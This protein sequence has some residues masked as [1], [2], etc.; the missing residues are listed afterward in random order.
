MPGPSPEGR[1]KSGIEG[2]CNHLRLLKN[3]MPS[4]RAARPRGSEPGNAITE[5]R[6][7]RGL[8]FDFVALRLVS[9]ET[10]ASYGAPDACSSDGARWKSD[11]FQEM[12]EQIADN[13]ADECADGCRG[14]RVWR[15]LLGF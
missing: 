13:A 8:P 3:L 4:S 10:P 6:E 14:S 9:Q 2:E 11:L 12:S 7:V 5:F 1:T 15:N